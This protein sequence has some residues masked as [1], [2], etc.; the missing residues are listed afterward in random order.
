MRPLG[1]GALPAI[2]RALQSAVL[3]YNG[4]TDEERGSK[5]RL[6]AAYGG[7]RRWGEGERRELCAG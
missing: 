3:K 2:V 1:A 7:W 6:G 5:E 4:R